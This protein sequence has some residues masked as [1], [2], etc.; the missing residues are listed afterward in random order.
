VLALL[1]LS[2]SDE[3]GAAALQLACERFARERLEALGGDVTVDTAELEAALAW[4]Q[5]DRQRAFELLRQRC[6]S[7]ASGVGCLRTLLGYGNAVAL[8]HQVAAA[9]AFLAAACSSDAA[10]SGAE[11]EVGTTMLGRGEVRL[12]L[13]HW[14]RAATLAPSEAAWR[15][16]G[17]L[18]R[19]S[20]QLAVLQ[21][22]ISGLSSLGVAV[23]EDFSNAVQRLQ[24]DRLLSP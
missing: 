9:E 3:E 18:A 2:S 10:C 7:S 13:L 15:R 24:R 20:G 11:T 23:P 19:D 17:E 1:A 21:Q 6:P 16:V 5:G 4:H 8:Q 22:A 12:A 14:V